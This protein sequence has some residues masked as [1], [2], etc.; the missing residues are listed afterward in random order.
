MIGYTA[1]L[2]IP[3][4]GEA[5]RCVYMAK[6]EKQPFEKL[7]GTVIAERVVDLLVLLLIMLFTIII[8][9][10]TLEE[11][12]IE[13]GFFEKFKGYKLYII[14]VLFFVGA[15]VFWKLI[16][17]SSI[18]FFVKIRGFIGGILEGLKTIYT[19]K[20]KGAFLFYTIV[21]WVLYILMFYIA[22]FSLPDTSEVPIGGVISAFVIGSLSIAA[23]NGGIGAYPLGIQQI[24]LL[25]NVGANEGLAFGWIVW[26]AQ[27]G[28]IVLFGLLSIILMPIFNR[29]NESIA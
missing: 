29:S 5:S 15:F 7:F 24:L 1:N 21:I 19:M 13:V 14:L 16:K 2:L 20:K 27:S 12:L 17:S 11:Y 26:V 9:F 22:F 23:T 6:Y 18:K 3:R 8:Q 25:Y 4:M 10:G 28:M